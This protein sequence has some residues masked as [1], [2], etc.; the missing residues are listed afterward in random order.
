MKLK[1]KGLAILAMIVAMCALVASASAPPTPFMISGCVNDSMGSPVNNP[2]VTITNLDTGK[3]FIAETDASSNYYQR[4]LA[5][6]TDVNTSETL[7]FDVR[8]GSQSNITE[9]TVTIEDVNQGGI[10]DFNIMLEPTQI[11]FDTGYGTYPSIMGTHTGNF[12]PK[13]DITVHQ[14]YTYPCV[15]TG[16]HSERAIFWDGEV[17]KINESWGGYQGDYHNIT[18]SPPVKLL[19]GKEY[20][21][22]IKTGSYS[23]IIH[24][25]TC[26]NGFG[27]MTCTRFVD[28]NG[29]EYNDW[30]PAIRLG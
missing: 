22:E 18:V 28:A 5:N 13:C 10:F 2:S 6:G 9:L 15:G 20:C 16:G 11:I 3:V 19:E 24:N 23:Q 7:Q 17:E 25:Q 14:I 27:T 21:Y 1:I 30:I 12:T 4:I 26:E 8:D 29:R